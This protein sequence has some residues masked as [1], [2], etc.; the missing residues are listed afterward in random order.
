[1][2]PT[3]ASNYIRICC[4]WIKWTDYELTVFHLGS[5]LAT[6]ALVSRIRNAYLVLWKRPVEKYAEVAQMSLPVSPTYK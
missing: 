5:I 4:E 1:M 2:N 3:L 6:T